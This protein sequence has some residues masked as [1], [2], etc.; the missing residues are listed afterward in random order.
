MDTITT[1]LEGSIFALVGD[2][3]LRVLEHKCANYNTGYEIKFSPAVRD[4]GI[5]N[6]YEIQAL[7]H[8][9]RLK[10]KHKEADAIVN[11]YYS[12]MT[13]GMKKPLF[14]NGYKPQG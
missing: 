8:T 2:D 14:L 9:L 6:D 11:K 4:A 5:A 3:I 7:Y 1:L 10:L 13:P 12:A